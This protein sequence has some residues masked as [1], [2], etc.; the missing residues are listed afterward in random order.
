MISDFLRHSFSPC[1]WVRLCV[2]DGMNGWLPRRGGGSGVRVWA[3]VSVVGRFPRLS[4][5]GGCV[6]PCVA[7]P[8]VVLD[9]RPVE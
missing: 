7:L 8:C 5:V 6:L 1:L 3:G 9:G 2:S 4:W